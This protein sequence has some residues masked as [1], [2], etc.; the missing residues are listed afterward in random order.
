MD[1]VGISKDYEPYINK[2]VDEI[3]TYVQKI[4]KAD[5]NIIQRQFDYLILEQKE[6]KKELEQLISLL[7][8]DK[9][10]EK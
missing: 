5:L 9:L 1:V 2:K 6:I 8:N 4:S 3:K 7:S 10:D